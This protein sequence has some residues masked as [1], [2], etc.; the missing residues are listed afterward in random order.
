MLRPMYVIFDNVAKVY[1][2]PF[3]MVNDAA[4]LRAAHNLAQDATTDIYK[5]PSDF[6]MYKIGTYDDNT[7]NIDQLS[8]PECII[9]F[10]E[11]VVK[12]DKDIDVLGERVAHLE[13]KLMN[14]VQQENETNEPTQFQRRRRV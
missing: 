9:R 7:G 5:N 14:A 1:N 8:Q 3:T 12:Q 10:Q 2:N 6:V 4:A 11:I 13:E